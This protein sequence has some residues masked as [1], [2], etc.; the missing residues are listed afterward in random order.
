MVNAA[1]GEETSLKRLAEHIADSLD[2][3]VKIQN[4]NNADAVTSRAK[5]DINKIKAFV[6]VSKFRKMS[7]G[8]E[9][10]VKQ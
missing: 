8:I 10:M 1:S 9:V 4:V 5:I 6:D 2:T 7:K 3:E